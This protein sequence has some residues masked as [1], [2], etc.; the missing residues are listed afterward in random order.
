MRFARCGVEVVEFL[1]WAP[2]TL[3][4][5]TLVSFKSEVRGRRGSR[6]GTAVSHPLQGSQSDV[7]GDEY[8]Q[9]ISP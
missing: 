1:V 4:P 7:V 5:E 8:L 9:Y 3:K 6:C 2:S